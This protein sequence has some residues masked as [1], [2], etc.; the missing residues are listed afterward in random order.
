MRLANKRGRDQTVAT[1]RDIKKRIQS[2][3]NT[4]KITS[5]M[6]MVSTSKMKK[7]QGRLEMTKPYETRSMRFFR[8]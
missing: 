6:E 3:T 4:R 8:T 7:M 1:Q 2:V 5:T